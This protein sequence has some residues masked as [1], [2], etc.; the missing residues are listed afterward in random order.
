MNTLPGTSTQPVWFV[1]AAYGKTDDQTSRFLSEGLW[2]NGYDDKHLDLVRSMQVGER[3]AIKSS[4]TQLHDLP[5][6][7]QGNRVSVMAIK[8]IGVITENRNDGK[9]VSVDWAPLQ[10]G[11]KW[12]F[13]THRGTIWRVQPGDW[14]NDGLIALAFENAPQDIQRFCNAPYWKARFGSQGAGLQKFSWTRFYMAVADGL[15]EYRHNRKALVA[16]LQEISTRVA[17]LGY[18][19]ADTYPN[20]ERG[21]VQDICPFTVMG[22][23]NRQTTEIN[24]QSIATEIAKFLGVDQPVP[25]SFEG[26]PVLHNLKSWFFPREIHRDADHIDSLWETFAAAIAYADSEGDQAEVARQGFAKAFDTSSGR[27]GVAWNLTMGLYWV[28][29]WA[30]LSLDELSRTFIRNTLAISIS[31]NG[32]NKR[33]SATDYLQVVDILEPRFQE[34]SYP[35][36]SFPELSLQAWSSEPEVILYNDEATQEELDTDESLEAGA[37]TLTTGAYP[38]M[39]AYTLDDILKEGCFLEYT[40]LESMLIRLREKKNLILQGPPG[41]GKT[42]LA[43]R[44]AF[45]L[46]GARDI[47]KVR[48]VQFHPNLSYEDFVRGWRPNGQGGLALAEGVFMEVIKAALNNPDS[49]FVVVIEEIN[50]GNPAQIFGELLTLL[51]AGKRT[52]SEALELSYPDAEGNRTSVHIPENLHVIGTMNVADRSLALVDLALRR[53]FAFIGL[54]PRLGDRWRKWVIEQGGVDAGLVQDIEGRMGELNAKIAEDERLGKQFQIGHSYVTP[55]ELLD[56]GTTRE[57]F[58]RVVE[59]EIAPLL[60]EYWADTP[61][62]AK[63]AVV[64]LLS[65]W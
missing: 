63:E 3:I 57:W 35:A 2:E 19:D 22:A 23:F 41:T 55:S 10:P 33:C 14:K 28:R 45:A 49:T 16:G 34:K 12:Y 40:E 37:D 18:L 44:L 36:H 43:K 15:L 29:P 27:P 25:T 47:K 48:S 30:L 42:W 24:R 8:A 17:A 38:V 58:I 1:G 56:E 5:F 39:P 61:A 26:V 13:Y 20:G 32:P 65:G 51:E 4:Y 31:T 6:D 53:R 64:N 60:D 54:T 7:N 50:R 52:P 46:I 11:R 21:F 59:T 62:S 9:R